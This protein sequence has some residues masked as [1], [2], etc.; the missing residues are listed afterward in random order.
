MRGQWRR[1]DVL[2]LAG[3]GIRVTDSRSPETV[4]SVRACPRCGDAMVLDAGVKNRRSW[5]CPSCG[6]IAR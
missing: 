3:Q 5:Q 6:K 2:G 4:Y 1:Q